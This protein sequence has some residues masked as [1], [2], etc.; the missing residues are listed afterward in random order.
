MEFK[1]DDS[2]SITFK[3]FDKPYTLFNIGD[4]FKEIIHENIT[5]YK[6]FAKFVEKSVNKL[7]EI[8]NVTIDIDNDFVLINNKE[9]CSILEF[10]KLLHIDYVVWYNK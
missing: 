10:C 4:F 7:Y 9:H 3:A 6:G 2:T 1:L 8:D 5:N